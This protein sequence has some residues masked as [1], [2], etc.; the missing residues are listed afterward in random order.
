MRGSVNEVPLS[1]EENIVCRCYVV[2]EYAIRRTIRE[3][4][5]QDIPSLTACTNAG[6]GCQSCWPD[7]QILLDDARGAR[8]AVATHPQPGSDA[9]SRTLLLNL[10]HDELRPLFELN[11]IEIHLVGVDGPRALIRFRGPGVG[12]AAPSF[13]AIKRFLV[14]AMVAVCRFPMMLVEVNVLE[15]HGTR[16][17]IPG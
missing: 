15:D 11:R 6:G 2:T 14:Q 16:M 8:P 13:L 3:R 5:L 9:R 1:P 7:L 10:L 4:R 12:T 17:R